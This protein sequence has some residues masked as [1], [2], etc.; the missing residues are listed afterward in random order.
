MPHLNAG[1]SPTLLRL[2]RWWI[3]CASLLIGMTAPALA[4]DTDIVSVGATVLTKNNCKFN[5]PSS[6][7]LAFGNIDPS[8]SGN[9][10]A[11][12]TLSIRCGGASPIVSYALNHDSGLHETGVNANRMKQATLNEYLPYALTL[13]PAS[14]TIP[15]NTDQTITLSGTITPANFQN[16]AMGA[17][18]DTVV[19]TLSP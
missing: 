7:S 6:A 11:T 15:K 19:I 1:H 12:A 14:G 3:V 18:A 8:S 13:T 16:A 2:G 10:T 9:A 17:Y 4:A 5:N